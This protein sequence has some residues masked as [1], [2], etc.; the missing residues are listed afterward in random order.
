MAAEADSRLSG[1]QASVVMAVA[2]KRLRFPLPAD[3]SFCRLA[4]VGP[5]K[6]DLSDSFRTQEFSARMAKKAKAVKFEMTFSSARALSCQPAGF[7]PRSEYAV[8]MC[9]EAQSLG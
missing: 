5:E 7:D 2:A 4:K 1:K 9:R 3:S 6:L 8:S